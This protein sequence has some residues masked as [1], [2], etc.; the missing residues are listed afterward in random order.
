MSKHAKKTSFSTKVTAGLGISTL[1][2]APVVA[3]S[4]IS[5]AADCD[6]AL[7]FSSLSN[8]TK[9]TTAL[10]GG[11]C[12]V[13]IEAENA[14]D[15]YGA[16][17]D[18]ELNAEVQ[19]IGILLV[20]TGA[21]A[22]AGGATYT[23]GHGG[24]LVYS[25]AAN[26]FTVGT[27]Y[28]G[29][30]GLGGEEAF[31][32]ESDASEFLLST[33]VANSAPYHYSIDQSTNEPEIP[34]YP[35]SVEFLGGAIALSAGTGSTAPSDQTGFPYSGGSGISM[36]E[37]VTNDQADESLWPSGGTTAIEFGA[38]GSIINSGTIPSDLPAGTGG[39]VRYFDDVND[40]ISASGTPGTIIF[41]FL[42]A[43]SDPVAVR[44]VT[45]EGPINLV[46]QVKAPVNNFAVATGK[47]LDTITR[48]RVG[49]VEVPFELLPDGKLKFNTPDLQPGTYQV[50]YEVGGTLTLTGSIALTENKLV[51][52]SESSY[53]VSKL[54]ANF[55]GDLFGVTS[56]DSSAIKNFIQDYDGITNITCVGSTSGVP[57]VATDEALAKAR[58]QNSC[59]LVES[60]VP[61]AKVKVLT[62]TGKGIGQNYRSVRIFIRGNN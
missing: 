40:N 17:F 48:V 3:N 39:W 15:A 37:L 14:N 49:G 33:G 7:T 16:G 46:T 43:G 11:L 47:R 21:N 60:L 2:L 45:Y 62:S 1:A 34:S 38:G 26:T 35:R 22:D 9:T 41:R 6:S 51:S 50:R 54:F 56:A 23:S 25:E 30:F 12:E 52:P 20:G 19:K 4:S 29:Y 8:A 59:D 55:G 10:S 32:K 61:G 27:S 13:K 24:Q 57:A 58:A 53:L 44:Q 5:Q 42:L 36:A 28:S 31:V 18:F